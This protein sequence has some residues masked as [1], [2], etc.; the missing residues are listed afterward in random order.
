MILNK[1]SLP[2]NHDNA[3]RLIRTHKE[4]SSRIRAEASYMAETAVALPFF[5]GFAAVLLFFFQVLCVQQEVGGALLVTGREMS[6]LECGTKKSPEGRAILAETMLVKNL[7]ADSSAEQFVRGGRLG[8]SLARSEF[9][10][11]YICLQA[12]YRMRLPLGLFGMR[13]IPM[14]QRLTCRKW[15]GEDFSEED[16]IVYITKKGSVYH[17]ERSCSYLSPSVTQAD[18]GE[19]LELRNASGG[20]YYPCAKCVKGKKLPDKRVYVTKYGSRYHGKK[21]CSEI[22]RTAVAAR[23]AEVKD[24]RACSK[25][26][27]EG[28][29]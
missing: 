26:G 6:A 11:N 4:A 25:C 23:L 5:A 13:D 12:D 22:A 18:V 10:G 7:K 3:R 24:R 27:R 21:N 19:I 20:K 28:R 2:V 16:E 15:T 9:S 29:L 1:I 8:I 14:A 17:R